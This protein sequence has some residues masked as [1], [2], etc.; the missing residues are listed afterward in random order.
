MSLPTPPPPTQPA[1]ID[2]EAEE[3][4]AYDAAPSLS[5]SPAPAPPSFFRRGYA[6]V[7]DTDDGTA[8][9]ASSSSSSSSAP[10]QQ[11]QTQSQT[12]SKTKTPLG[13]GTDGVFS[14]LGVVQKDTDESI[15]SSNPPEYRNV[16]ND[17]V[18]QSGED[19][20][21]N[22][23]QYAGHHVALSG[24][25][26]QD[27]EILIEGLPVGD[28]FSFLAN[29]FVSMT[30]DFLGYMMT[31]LLATSHAARCGS[32]S[33]L[34]MTFVRYGMIVLEKD[35]EV[36]EYTFRTNPDDYERVQEIGK[37]N[38]FIAYLMIAFGFFL[39]MVCFVFP[40]DGY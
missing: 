35:Q 16:F 13:L 20:N 11:P 9:A 40:R 27:G 14:N 18:T 3:A 36:E 29:F 30:F 26:A 39:M 24:V 28:F 1:T 22:L 32:R 6:P 25:V 33:G 21:S 38:D 19:D 5:P 34:G 31:T 12:S 10:Q 23:P 8:P 17:Q 37:H 2:V 4:P 7:A 15:P